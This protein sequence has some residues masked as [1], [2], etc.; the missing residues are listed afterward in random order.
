MYAENYKIL[1][2][3]IKDLNKRR[4]IPCPWVERFNI[5]KMPILHKLIYYSLNAIPIKIPGR[6]FVEIDN[7]CRDRVSSKIYIFKQKIRIKCLKT[8]LA[9]LKA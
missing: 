1:M 9:H 2:K 4:D 6:I 3:E 8:F 5:V 7:F